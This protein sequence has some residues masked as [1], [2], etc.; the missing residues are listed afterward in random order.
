M[1]AER[2]QNSEPLDIMVCPR[3]NTDCAR[4]SMRVHFEWGRIAASPDSLSLLTFP[5]RRSGSTGVVHI[6]A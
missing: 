5:L 3:T 1:R 6:T 4:R 2:N